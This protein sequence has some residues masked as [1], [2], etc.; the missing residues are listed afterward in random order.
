MFGNNIFSFH[1]IF[2]FRQK[3][4]FCAPKKAVKYSPEI[5]GR[6]A[7]RQEEE[8][9]LTDGNFPAEFPFSR[10]LKEQMTAKK[11]TGRRLAALAGTTEATISR[12]AEGTRRPDALYALAGIARTLKVSSDYLLGLTD[13]PFEKGTLPEE[14]VF[15]LSGWL[16]ADEGD[17][18]VIRA[19]LSK[20]ERG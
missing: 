6:K 2:I 11:M 1:K 7:P 14:V 15:L 18:A 19:V 10:R 17:R 5:A 8:K 4:G 20:Y 13:N 9:E 16:K 12:Y 3:K